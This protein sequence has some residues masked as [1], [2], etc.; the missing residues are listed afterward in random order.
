M[1]EVNPAV[2]GFG[3]R[4]CSFLGE[5]KEKI[6]ALGGSAGRSGDLCR[7]GSEP[8]WR[9]AGAEK[10]PQSASS[11]E[12]AGW[13]EAT[14]AEERQ[15]GGEETWNG[16]PLRAVDTTAEPSFSELLER[17]RRGRRA[18]AERGT[19]RTPP[20]RRAGAVRCRSADQTSDPHQTQGGETA[21]SQHQESQRK[22]AG[23]TERER[24]ESPLERDSGAERDR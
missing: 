9:T 3:C 23:G 24:R 1:F 21:R 4:P 18:A 5:G 19:P 14:P 2:R 22:P 15:R 8:D 16:G 7:V 6:G 12:Q 13:G 10:P 17:A 11:G 20:G